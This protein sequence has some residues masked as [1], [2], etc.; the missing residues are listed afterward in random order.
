[1]HPLDPMELKDIQISIM[2]E[3][4]SYCK[5]HNLAYYLA[6]GTLLG[7]VRHKGFIPW[8]DDVDLIMPRSD[9]EKFL[10]EFSTSHCK[11]Y[12]LYTSP[13]CRFPFAKVYDT[14]T[15]VIE[16]SF[17]KKADFGV[18]VDI[19][20]LD[21]ASDDSL[22]IHKQVEHSR[23]YQ[24]LLKIKLSRMGKH[25]N[26]SQNLSILVG[27]FFLLPFSTTWFSRKIDAVAKMNTH[28]QTNKMGCMVWGYREREILDKSSYA[29]GVP[30]EFEKLVFPA[31]CGYHEYLSSLYG[32]YM[33]LPPIEKQVSKHDFVAYWKEDYKEQ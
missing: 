31:P 15:S 25:W 30:I 19:F 16:G 2:K 32:D 20:P 27:N 3:I 5:E 11:V 6:G 4:D 9:Y 29:S 24:Q 17:R 18:F 33:K 14:R 23:F 13:K 7:A 8:D 22:L 10:T 26:L 12:S 21:I 1:M 28:L